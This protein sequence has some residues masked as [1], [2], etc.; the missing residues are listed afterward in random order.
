M[1]RELLYP[2]RC[3][4]CGQLVGLGKRLPLCANCDPGIY[5]P[6]GD[7]C[8]I[9]SRPVE[10]AGGRCVS[11]RQQERRIQGRGSFLYQD[12]MRQSVEDFKYN[13]MKEYAK[14]YALLMAY[15]DKDWIEAIENPFFV[16]VPIHTKR[17][18]E[19]GYNQAAELARALSKRLGAPLWDGLIRV[20]N[21]KPL[22]KMSAVQRGKSLEGAFR[23]GEGKI[24][25][26]GTAVLVDDIYTSGST[27]EACAAAL[28]EARPEQEIRFWSLTIRA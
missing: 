1:L 12:G 5:V 20:R 9:C 10:T 8:L 14:G 26:K 2:P 11:C 7:R 23:V 22:Q 15:Y 28:W 25:P 24:P 19:R 16:P 6:R 13:G 4:L 17:H 18:Q 21:T 27:V 3:L